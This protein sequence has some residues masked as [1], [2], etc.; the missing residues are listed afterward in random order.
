MAE[1]ANAA[2]I[3]HMKRIDSMVETMIFALVH[4]A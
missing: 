1:I 3:A 4:K 2:G